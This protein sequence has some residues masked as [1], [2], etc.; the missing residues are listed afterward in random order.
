MR[1]KPITEDPVEDRFA[2]VKGVRATGLLLFLFL[3]VIVIYLVASGVTDFSEI[4]Q[5]F[6]E[7]S[8][9]IAILVISLSICNYLL[10]G[11]RWKWF[12]H[13]VGADLGAWAALR[14]YVAG[15]AFGVTPARIG[16]VVRIQF[17]KSE[18][19]APYTK[20]MT[21]VIADR[22][23]DLLGLAL[24]TLVASAVLAEA[25]SLT[26]AL[27]AVAAVF[28]AAALRRPDWIVPVT[29]I[30]YRLTGKAA[31][32]HVGIRRSFRVGSA[33]YSSGSL[34]LSLVIGIAAW[35]A[36]CL[37]FYLVLT[38]LGLGIDV[39][40]ATLIYA[41]ATLIGALSFLPGGL[42]GF[43]AIAIVGLKQAGVDLPSAVM[44]VTAIRVL[45]LWLSVAVGWMVM[46]TMLVRWRKQSTQA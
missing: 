11:L 4:R 23:T 19:G 29:R 18:F 13:V 12:C 33:I 16:E 2:V 32:F 26:Y 35:F 41:A 27:I 43:E 46:G 6:D 14:H 17:L 34:F 31:R 21:I 9:G 1:S 39:P 44:A 8:A 36:E 45:T 37:G 5:V 20:G 3:T 25:N 15:F 40:T 30:T 10:R 28:F 22:L 24:L 7:F 38:V 42:G